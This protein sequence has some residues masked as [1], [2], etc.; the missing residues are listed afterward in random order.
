MEA[1][2][3]LIVALALFM[4]FVFLIYILSPLI[5]PKP[6]KLNG[7]HVIITGGSSGIGKAVAAEVLNQG[8]NVTI[9]ARNQTRLKQAKQELEEH[10]KDKNTQ[11]IL[12]ISVDVAKEYSAVEKAVKEACDVLGPCD[13]LVN[14][15]GTSTAGSF[16]EMDVSEFRKLM[17]VNYLGTVYPTKA[18][19]PYMK[20]QSQGRIV[21]VSSQAGQIGLFGYT[22]YS[23]SKFALM[24]FAEA[25]QME[26]KP[27]NIYLTINFPPDTQ[28]PLYEEDLKRSPE[29]TVLISQ[30]SGL[31]QPAD[32]AS[33][34]VTDSKNAVFL[35]WIG[36]DGF[37]L[38]NMTCGMS[39]VTSMMEGVQQ[40]VTMGIFRI[41]SFFYL[42][43]FDR[44]V[45]KCKENRKKDKKD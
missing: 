31:Y 44:I 36:L 27:Y 11:K 8:A 22:A 9:M 28:T 29:E 39:P 35:S 3:F 34:I 20:Q 18:V 45:R 12:C 33:S 42:G 6:L 16:E 14:S 15:A 2:V 1:A 4:S 43:M 21:F 40:V 10:I 37:M 5:T 19:L 13:M 38:A 30:T 41:V 24:G 25:L 32:V 23:G 17:D 26:V 7:A